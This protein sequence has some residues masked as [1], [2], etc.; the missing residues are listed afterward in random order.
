MQRLRWTVLLFC[1]S[2]SFLHLVC[3]LQLHHFPMHIQVFTMLWHDSWTQSGSDC[4]M[5]VQFERA[6]KFRI[7]H[8]IAGSQ[9]VSWFEH[10]LLHDLS[11]KGLGT[12]SEN[13]ERLLLY[14]IIFI[15]LSEQNGKVTRLIF[16]IYILHVIL[17]YY[18]L[19]YSIK[20]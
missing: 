19:K 8:H 15:Q 13:L 14:N 9:P 12:S 17:L 7:F 4:L 3:A 2:F 6:L 20:V 11:A 5:A 16:Q 18:I 10:I 1:N